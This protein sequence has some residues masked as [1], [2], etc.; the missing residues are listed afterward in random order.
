MIITFGGTPGSGKSTVAKI[1]SEKLNYPFFDVGKMRRVA[2]KEKNM[3]IEEFNNWSNENPKEGDIYFDEFVKEVVSKEKNAVVCG[4]MAYFV[5]KNS[6]KI[7]LAVNLEEGAR[8]IFNE[9][10]K[11]NERN[12]EAVNSI[13]GQKKTIIQRMKNDTKR[14]LNLYNTDCYDKKNFDIVIDT[15]ELS[16]E[17]VVQEIINK[18]KNNN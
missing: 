15:S 1:I 14:Y 10:Q 7:Y 2:A 4:R 3:T 9:T 12:E 6:I 18:I 13:D 17:E 16:V 11:N 5:F 8:R